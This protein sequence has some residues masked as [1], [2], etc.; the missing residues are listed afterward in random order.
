V[1][2]E[3]VLSDVAHQGTPCQEQRPVQ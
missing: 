2:Q 3:R 1:E